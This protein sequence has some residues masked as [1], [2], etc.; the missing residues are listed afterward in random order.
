M[1]FQLLV[2]TDDLVELQHD[3]HEFKNSNNT[4]ES[5]GGANQ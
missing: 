3:W 2:E 5:G 4:R 1:D